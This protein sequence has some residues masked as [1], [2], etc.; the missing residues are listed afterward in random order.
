MPKM[1]HIICFM[2]LMG[3]N[4]Y[5]AF[6][7]GAFSDE[8]ILYRG[9]RFMPFID[10]P[11]EITNTVQA[12]LTRQQQRQ[13]PAMKQKMAD[14]VSLFT[15]CSL[16][17]P[18]QGMKAVLT[19][20]I[21]PPL[22]AGDHEAFRGNLTLEL[23]VT[24]VCNERPCWDKKTDATLKVDIN[25]PSRL[26]AIH[27]MDEIWIGPRLVSEFF[28]HPVYRL[29]D[30]HREITVIT[31]KNV[32]PYLPVSRENFILTLI[33]HFEQTISAGESQASRPESETIILVSNPTDKER[34]KKAFDKD[35]ENLFRFDPLLAKKL[36]DNYLEAEKRL[37]QAKSDTAAAFTMANFIRMQM[38][39]WQ[40]GI[41][42]L[43]A[44]LNAMSPLERR[45]QAHWSDS[46][47]LNTSGL[48]PPG[49]PG[50]FPLVRINPDILDD[51]LPDTDIQLITV[52]WGIETEP[53]ISFK[54]GRNLQYHKLHLLH[55]CAEIWEEISGLI[56]V[57]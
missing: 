39:V 31:K 5:S 16:L 7:Q 3:I 54:R 13:L 52:E 34:R 20:G 50:S 18:P 43:R 51:T 12:D 41:R 37:E 57:E 19:T 8:I 45:A 49:H 9:E 6:A 23:Y 26:A 33:N 2:A 32:P 46:E 14:V 30:G 1:F 42:K 22:T 48:T 21:Q 36:N 29:N 24:M 44:E 40:E 35:Y 55:E 56:Q 11:I 4:L 25:D 28:G 47:T 10:G 27:V 15:A 53:Y 38:V 17:N